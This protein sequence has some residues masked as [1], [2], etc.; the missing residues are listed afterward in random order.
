MENNAHISY[1]NLHTKQP[2]I[3][4]WRQIFK[5]ISQQYGALKYVGKGGYFTQYVYATCNLYGNIINSKAR[6]SLVKHLLV[7]NGPFTATTGTTVRLKNR[8]IS[9]NKISGGYEDLDRNY[10]SFSVVC[11][12]EI[13][14]R[15]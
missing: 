12:K 13:D 4:W 15:K 14:L 2:T 8:V 3:N 11:T 10:L 6:A 1:H 9:L 7:I 5:I